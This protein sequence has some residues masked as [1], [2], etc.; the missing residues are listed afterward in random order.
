VITDKVSR[1]IQGFDDILTNLVDLR[2]DGYIQFDDIFGEFNF[3]LGESTTH[4]SGYSL[5]L[6]RTEEQTEGRG[7]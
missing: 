3:I 6:R 5:L 4:P 7:A 1:W 2:F